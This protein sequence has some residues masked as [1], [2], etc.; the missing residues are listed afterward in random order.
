MRY[1]L[2]WLSGCRLLGRRDS[3]QSL[4]VIEKFTQRTQ[5]K[6]Y[7]KKIIREDIKI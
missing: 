5:R 1:E 3:L 6:E 4:M 7:A 2:N